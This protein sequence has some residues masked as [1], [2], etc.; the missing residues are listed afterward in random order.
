VNKDAEIHVGGK[1]VGHGLAGMVDALPEMFAQ[2]HAQRKT[3]EAKRVPMTYADWQALGWEH[4]DVE[5]NLRENVQ[6]KTVCHVLV[7]PDNNEGTGYMYE[8]RHHVRHSPTGFEW[9]YS[10]SGPAELARC[11]LIDYL[12]LHEEAEQ[13][14]PF[15]NVPPVS[16]QDFKQR[17]IAPAAKEGFALDGTEIAAWLRE[18]PVST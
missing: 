6:T 17:F 15:W 3:Y 7:K 4:E 2:A 13:D 11:I 9:G 10:G 12:D 16:Y 1:L 14:D 8:L 5:R 18:Q